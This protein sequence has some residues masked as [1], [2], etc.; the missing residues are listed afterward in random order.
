M[1]GA[2]PRPCA[3]AHSARKPS[4]T[5]WKPSSAATAGF[6]LQQLEGAGR[7][8]LAAD[9]VIVPVAVAQLARQV[10]QVVRV[11]VDGQDHRPLG[12]HHD[13]ILA[14]RRCGGEPVGQPAQWPA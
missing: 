10:R 11:V 5:E 1:T 13:E 6:G 4:T 8:A 12:V 7:R 9:V 3:L 14:G 2:K